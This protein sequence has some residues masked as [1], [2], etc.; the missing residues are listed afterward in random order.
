[1][2]PADSN[3]GSIRRYLYTC[4]TCRHQF[5]VVLDTAVYTIHRAA[6]PN[7]DKQCYFDNR[8]GVLERRIAQRAPSG[9]SAH[10]EPAHSPV[11]GV[12]PDTR[13]ARDD[14]QSAARYRNSTIESVKSGG[15]SGS[16]RD[17]QNKPVAAK[18]SLLPT[19]LGWPAVRMPSMRFHWPRLAWRLPDI[20]LRGQ[21]WGRLFALAMVSGTAFMILLFLSLHIPW[22]WLG[23]PSSYLDNLGGTNTN[24]ILDRDGQLIGELFRKKTGNIKAESIPKEMAQTLI[25]VEDQDF[26]SHGGI[27]YSS[28]LRAL[29]ANITAFGYSQGGSTLTQQLAR[30]LL[31]NRHK[32]ML[33]KLRETALAWY[34]ES[35]LSKDQILAAYMSQVYLGHGSLGFDNAARFYFGKEIKALN[36]SERLTLACLPSAPEKYSPLRN[37]DLLVQKMDLVYERMQAANLQIPPAGPFHKELAALFSSLNQSPIASIFG[38]RI[39]DAPYV[40]EHIRLLIRRHLGPEYMYGAGLTIETTLDKKLQQKAV[41]EI[42]NHISEKAR[43]FPPV[44]MRDDKIVGRFGEKSNQ[45]FQLE[46][47]DVALGPMLF[48]LSVPPLRRPRLQAAAVGIDAHTGGILFMHG[49]ADFS[50][51][52]Q[53]NRAIQMRRQTGS[54][55]KPIVYSAAI[56]SGAVTAATMIED[57][58]IYVAGGN[59][60]K[61]YWLPGNY[62]GVYEGDIPVRRAL[63]KSQNIPAIQVL[64]HASLERV[65][66]QFQKF[67]FP[68]QKIFDQRFRKDETVAIGSL[69]MSPLEMATAYTAFG[70]NGVIKRPFIVKRI[71]DATGQVL[72]HYK[73]HDEFELHIPLERSVIRADAAQ[74]MVSLMEDSAHFGG[75]GRGGFGSYHIGKTGTSNQ[76]RDT[77]FVGLVPGIS[78]VVWVG[79]DNPAWSMYK[80]TGAGLA[81]PL[82]GRILRHFKSA[83]KSFQ[84]DPVAVTARVCADT[85]RQPTAACRNVK[86]ELF[87]KDHLPPQSQKEDLEK[88]GPSKTIENLENIGP[89]DSDFD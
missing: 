79:Y 18:K 65:A 66:E 55:I 67:F 19:W 56:E 75:T 52:N 26:Y 27:Q 1:M 47:E 33:R 11:S 57:R 49:G 73:E 62:S 76:Y 88:A 59:S 64:R 74:I 48:G 85:G 34:L 21:S 45:R 87:L 68:D 29:W 8:E 5:K 4:K 78:A 77:W 46:F 71:L 25:F 60:A 63:A 15:A 17:Y 24:R 36:F 44:L 28:I 38:K 20:D 84:F 50:S 51:R 30:I 23:N 32:T 86:T 40:T 22:L 89:G 70:N 81:G 69:E 39:N 53:L 61:G 10:Q 35:S 13:A 83:E 42:Y 43:Y 72:Y 2:S 80:G 3:S 9:G 14:G 82:W 6:C 31:A 37:P 7:C 54:S 16:G 41:T 12:H 58:P